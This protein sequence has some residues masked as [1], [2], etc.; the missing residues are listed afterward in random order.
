[1]TQQQEGS[2]QKEH[3][4][5]DQMEHFQRVYHVQMVME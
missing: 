2:Q 1:M 3:Q 5:R 4:L